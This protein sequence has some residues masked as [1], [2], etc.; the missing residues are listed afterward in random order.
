MKLNKKPPFANTSVD[1]DKS[2][3][4]IDKMLQEFGA[5]AVNWTTDWKN[6]RVNLKF[7]LETEFEGVKKKIGIDITPPI[8]ASEHRSWN[9]MSGRHERVVAPNWAQS[10]RLLFWW[11]KSKLEAV[12]F[13]LSSAEQEFLSQVMVQLPTGERG[14]IG[15]FIGQDIGKGKLLLEANTTE[16]SR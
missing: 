5:E 15:G 6:N 14:T 11:L 16:G 2:R 12:T 9:A 7:L 10:M 8:F 13:G 3:A 1:P 4:E